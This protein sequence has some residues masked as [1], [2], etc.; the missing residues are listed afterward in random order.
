MTGNAPYREKGRVYKSAV[1]GFKVESL[2]RTRIESEVVQGRA[3][4]IKGRDA[5]R[6]NELCKDGEQDQCPQ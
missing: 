6:K 3:D 2:T 5:V 4:C 1:L